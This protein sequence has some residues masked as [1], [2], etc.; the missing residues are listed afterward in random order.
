M[1][2]IQNIEAVMHLERMR[3]DK[4]KIA[5]INDVLQLDP[6]T[7]AKEL[8]ILKEG[9][10]KTHSVTYATTPIEQ[11]GHTI[12]SVDA[13][14]TNSF[15]WNLGD[16]MDHFGMDPQQRD[17]LFKKYGLNEHDDVLVNYDIKI[18][19]GPHSKKRS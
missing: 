7:R 10:P 5:T 12:Q 3:R 13:D 1:S 15:A 16:M 4:S 17:A 6:A 18:Q 14:L 11:S 2:T 9:V 19:V 8:K